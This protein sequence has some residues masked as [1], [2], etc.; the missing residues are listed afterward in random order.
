MEIRK[1]WRQFYREFFDEWCE[2]KGTVVSI[3][4][5]HW[6]AVYVSKKDK[7]V[8]YYDP[9]GADP[10]EPLKDLLKELGRRMGGAIGN[11]P[12]FVLRV[13]RARHQ[14]DTVSCG[15]Y[16]LAFLYER[17]KRRKFEECTVYRQ[18]SSSIMDTYRRIFFEG[19]DK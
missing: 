7:T 3:G 11:G 15:L 8:D 6:A 12:K 9:F 16:S 17:S 14:T 4:G 10:S 1:V 2:G 18:L 5:V 19:Q 13:S